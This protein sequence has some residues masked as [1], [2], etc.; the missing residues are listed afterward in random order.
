MFLTLQNLLYYFVSH[1]CTN[2]RGYN[3]M[4]IYLVILA[5]YLQVA[6]NI[7]ELIGIDISVVD[8]GFNVNIQI[9]DFLDL[10]KETL[11]HRSSGF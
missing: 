8:T 6:D 9:V 10:S 2:T 3:I 1:Y 4:T 5:A 11:V 7:P